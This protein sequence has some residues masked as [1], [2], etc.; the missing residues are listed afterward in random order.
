MG[1]RLRRHGPTRSV[2]DWRASDLVLPEPQVSR[3][4]VP[5]GGIYR[6]CLASD[7]LWDCCRF[8]QCAVELRRARSVASASQALLAIAEREYLEV[9]GHDLMD[10]DT[11]AIVLELS[12][13]ASRH[14]GLPTATES[15][16]SSKRCVVA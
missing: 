6:V 2:G 5:A 7:G 13:S 4:T 15:G 8:E 9:R 12:P 3:F 14:R 11:T 10:D 16:G 1:W